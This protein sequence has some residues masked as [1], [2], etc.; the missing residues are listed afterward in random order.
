MTETATTPAR[1]DSDKAA[2]EDIKL[3]TRLIRVIRVHRRP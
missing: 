2:R 3:E 1:A